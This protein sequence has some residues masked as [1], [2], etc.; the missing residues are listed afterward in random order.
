MHNC[1]C[2]MEL[3]KEKTRTTCSSCSRTHRLVSDIWFDLPPPPFPLHTPNWM[4]VSCV[5]AVPKTD[6]YANGNSL[7][8]T[9]TKNTNA[10]AEIASRFTSCLSDAI[11]AQDWWPTGQRPGSGRNVLKQ[12]CLF[13]GKKWTA[14][15]RLRASI[16]VRR[17]HEKHLSRS[18]LIKS[19][20]TTMNVNS[21][22]VV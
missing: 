7:Q 11:I 20:I 6:S 10:P 13:N 12:R 4:W 2:N 5:L 21:C 14:H 8:Q 9:T 1:N 3:E 17:A 16:C 19:A 18:P 15:H 22:W